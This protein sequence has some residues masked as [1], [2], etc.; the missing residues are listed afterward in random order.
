[1]YSRDVKA[2]RTTQPSFQA[3][4]SVTARSGYIDAMVPSAQTR[5]VT[6]SL[7]DGQNSSSFTPVAKAE[8]DSVG[9]NA[10]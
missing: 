10:E 6:K 7:Q 1:M 8:K 3:R 2:E 5:T 4:D 9:D